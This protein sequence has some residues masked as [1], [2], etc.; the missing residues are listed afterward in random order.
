MNSNILD[1]NNRYCNP[2]HAV[3]QSEPTQEPSIIR[4][5]EEITPGKIKRTKTEVRGFVPVLCVATAVAFIAGVYFG[6]R[7][8]WFK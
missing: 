5:T 4:D 3:Q 6:P 2:L 8:G 7:L 1:W